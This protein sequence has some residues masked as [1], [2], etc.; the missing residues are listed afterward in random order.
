[1]PV[2]R[3]GTLGD[4][5]TDEATEFILSMIKRFMQ[6]GQEN[7]V[8]LQ[9]LLFSPLP[10]AVRGASFGAVQACQAEE[11]VCRAPALG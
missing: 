11:D 6:A 5:T 1:M 9:E 8:R 4:I 7:P 3:Y 2:V 10:N